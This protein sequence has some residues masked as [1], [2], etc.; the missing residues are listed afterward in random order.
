M[1]NITKKGI[2]RANVVS[3]V[4]NHIT[5]GDISTGIIEGDYTT[6]THKWTNDIP[7]GLNL[8]DE[9]NFMIDDINNVIR[10]IW[11]D[12][13]VDFRFGVYNINDFSTI[14]ESADGSDYTY[15]YGE[16]T[17]ERGVS[18][19]NVN[20]ASGGMSRSIATYSLILPHDRKTIEVWRGTL[21]SPIWSHDI[22]T[23]VPGDV[24]SGGGISLTGKYILVK[25]RDNKKLILYEG[26]A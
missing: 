11:A 1:A 4:N 3:V 8:T 24:V 7:G 12:D 23:E 17:Y 19:G 10:L 22:T 21:G 25:I 9:Y 14:L 16:V 2:T 5:E 18:I 13:D 20:L 6:W 15:E 26:S